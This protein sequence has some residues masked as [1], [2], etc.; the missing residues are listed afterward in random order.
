MVIE[1]G[2]MN[3]SFK[4][5]EWNGHSKKKNEMVING[6]MKWSFKKEE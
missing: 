5:E 2:R 1:K 4:K 6:R 3:W